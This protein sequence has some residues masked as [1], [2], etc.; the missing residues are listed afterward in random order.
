MACLGVVAESLLGLGP[1]AR[2]LFCGHEHTGHHRPTRHMRRWT[3]TFILARLTFRP[4]TS[5]DSRFLFKRLTLPARTRW[6]CSPLSHQ[7]RHARIVRVWTPWLR[8]ARPWPRHD[9]HSCRGFSTLSHGGGRARSFRC[10]AR[11]GAIRSGCNYQFPCF[12]R[13]MACLFPGWAP[14]C[15]PTRSGAAREPCPREREK[16]DGPQR[17]GRAGDGR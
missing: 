11:G 9:P 16:T 3:D 17:R 4:K 15:S 6:L 1:L 5:S 12:S 2:D 14:N 10:E 7:P 13:P 8:R